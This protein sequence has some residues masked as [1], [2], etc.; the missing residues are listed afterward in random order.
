MHLKN[1]TYNG[2]QGQWIQKKCDMRQIFAFE[3]Q[4]FFR[5]FYVN[6]F[7]NKKKTSINNGL[8]ACDAHT[9]FVIDGNGT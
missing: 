6:N 5:S 3:F 1:L 2:N 7:A 9:F 4:F 8:F